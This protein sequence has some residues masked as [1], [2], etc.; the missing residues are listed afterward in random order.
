M[1]TAVK[2][3]NNPVYNENFTVSIYNQNLLV[4]TV[5]KI[6]VLF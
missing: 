4:N 1:K 3:G 6:K 5:K 2:R